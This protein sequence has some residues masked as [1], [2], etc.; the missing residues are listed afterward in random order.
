MITISVPI[1]HISHSE[2]LNSI[3]EDSQLITGSR[4]LIFLV[5]KGHLY[6]RVWG[7]ENIFS[8]S[9]LFPED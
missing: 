1:L 8:K 9:F 5:Y 6:V 7:K 4:A 2:S 3:S